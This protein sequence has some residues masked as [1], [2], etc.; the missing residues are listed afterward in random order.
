MLDVE[1]KAAARYARHQ[2]VAAV[3]VLLCQLHTREVDD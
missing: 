3:L 1:A 2:V